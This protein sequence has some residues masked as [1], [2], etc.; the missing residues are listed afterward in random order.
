MGS[1]RDKPHFTEAFAFSK[2]DFTPFVTLGNV[3][4]DSCTPGLSRLDAP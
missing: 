2:R 1:K 4:V 3:G